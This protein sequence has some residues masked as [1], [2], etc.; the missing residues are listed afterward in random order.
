MNRNRRL[1]EERVRRYRHR[2][3]LIAAGISVATIA[4]VIG[5]G[6][7]LNDTF[8]CVENAISNQ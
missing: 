3:R 8:Q 1:P 5:L 4:V 2:I 7:E 6:T